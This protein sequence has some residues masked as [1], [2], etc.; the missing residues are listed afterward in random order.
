MIEWI[1]MHPEYIGWAC[2]SIALLLLLG[3]GWM[4]A[5]A[6]LVKRRYRNASIQKS[7]DDFRRRQ[8]LKRDD[9]ANED[10][11]LRRVR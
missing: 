5:S 2:F 1:A 9:E 8:Q 10:V 3:M 7:M 4:G 11:V 6:W